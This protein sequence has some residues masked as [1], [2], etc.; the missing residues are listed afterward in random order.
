MIDTG[1]KPKR[2]VYSSRVKFQAVLEVIKG[3]S[4]G[5]IARAYG[6]HPTMFSK[7]RRKFEEQGYQV[8]DEGKK[9]ESKNKIDE[10]TR[11]IGKKEVE[12]ELLKKF[13][14]SGD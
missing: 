11:L 2:K 8:F 10:L 13:V 1:T 3:K 5:E 6:F 9:D 4:V 14:G 7:W 12:I